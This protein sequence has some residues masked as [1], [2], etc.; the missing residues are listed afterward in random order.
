MKTSR[1][2]VRRMMSD[3]VKTQASKCRF[4]AYDHAWYMLVRSYIRRGG[5]LV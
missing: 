4:I 5:R 3:A 2:D 1:S